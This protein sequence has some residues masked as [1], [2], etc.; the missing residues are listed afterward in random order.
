MKGILSGC[1][2]IFHCMDDDDNDDGIF[3]PAVITDGNDLEANF[4]LTG[5]DL[6]AF[7]RRQGQ[8]DRGKD[9]VPYGRN[10]YSGTTFW[11]IF[12]FTSLLP[13]WFPLF[14]SSSCSILPL[15]YLGSNFSYFPSA[16]VDQW[17]G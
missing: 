16:P 15:P 10:T 3:L 12:A 14:I 2:G 9:K 7:T 13:P 5:F 17:S 6:F 4:H 1:C 8:R 11:R